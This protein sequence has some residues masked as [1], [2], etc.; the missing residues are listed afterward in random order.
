MNTKRLERMTKKQLINLIWRL[1]GWIHDEADL[2]EEEDIR[3]M[4]NMGVLG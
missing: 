3:W 2:W 1:S 4:F